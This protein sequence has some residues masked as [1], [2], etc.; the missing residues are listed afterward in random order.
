MRAI[1][2]TARLPMDHLISGALIAGITIGG[3]SYNEYKKGNISSKQA[4][5]KTIKLSIQGGLATACA[6]SASNRLVMGNYIGAA[7]SAA[8]G[9]G[10]II[11]TEKLINP[12]E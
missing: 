9:I 10:G 12:E 5:K 2:S 3:L 1:T 6:I 4:T 7:L 8:V 11:L